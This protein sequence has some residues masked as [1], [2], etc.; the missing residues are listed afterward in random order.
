MNSSSLLLFLLLVLL[1]G[2]LFFIVRADGG[3]MPTLERYNI[4]LPWGT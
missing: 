3:I 4:M 2:A 1:A